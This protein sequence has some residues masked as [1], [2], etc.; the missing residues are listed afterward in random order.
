LQSRALALDL[1][2]RAGDAP[3]DPAAAAQALLAAS[4]LAPDSATAY[5]A[6]VRTRFPGSPAAMVIDGRDPADAPEFDALAT[7][8][9]TIWA[10]ATLEWSD[11][12]RLRTGAPAPP[13]SV[14]R[15]AVPP[16]Q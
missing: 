14:K 11:S 12:L 4:A 3:G 7:R 1:F 8:L 5:L 9:R 16:P 2:R 6:R 13:D 15:P 10:N